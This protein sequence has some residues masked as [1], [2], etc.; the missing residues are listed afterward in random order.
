MMLGERE[1]SSY[2]VFLSQTVKNSKE[3]PQEQLSSQT[4]PCM[5]QLGSMDGVTENME[6]PLQPGRWSRPALGKRD[7]CLEDT[8]WILSTGVG[9]FHLVVSQELNS[10][11][12][13]GVNVPNF[14]SLNSKL[15][16]PFLLFLPR[17]IVPN[18]CSKRVSL[19]W[20]GFVFMSMMVCKYI[21]QFSNTEFRIPE[22]RIPNF[23]ST[24][25]TNILF[26]KEL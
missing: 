26:C 2:F 14:I 8:S 18:R 21:L 1:G 24:S 20:V 11:H 25:V 12:Y 23:P 3:I 5:H 17:V 22:N 19:N 9:L 6:P 15:Y 10:F 13:C 16:F 7:I 4:H